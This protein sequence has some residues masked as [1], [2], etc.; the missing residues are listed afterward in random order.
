MGGIGYY[1]APEGRT[2]YAHRC[3]LRSRPRG[4]LSFAHGVEGRSRRRRPVSD[5]LWILTLLAGTGD[6]GR[7][8]RFDGDATLSRAYQ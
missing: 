5:P 8:T 1:G 6:L 3:W 2:W 7:Q 4:M